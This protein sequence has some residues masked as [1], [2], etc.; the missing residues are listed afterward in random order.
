[1]LRQGAW[2]SD[3][4]SAQYG[5]GYQTTKYI[6]WWSASREFVR[7]VQAAAREDLDM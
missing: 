3:D 6:N 5:R 1:M 2:H 7:E 4:H